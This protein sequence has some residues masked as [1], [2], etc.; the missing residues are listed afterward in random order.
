M[1]NLLIV[2]VATCSFVA[3]AAEVGGNFKSK[4]DVNGVVANVA[5]G[6][7]NTQSIALGSVQGKKAKVKGNFNSEVKVNG[8]VANVAVGGF[9]KQEVSLGSVNDGSN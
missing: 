4:V 3:G 8:V 6:G 1:K 9:N 7:K 5:V 2:A